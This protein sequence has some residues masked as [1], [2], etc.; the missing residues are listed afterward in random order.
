MRQI[1]IIKNIRDLNLKK[2]LNKDK[3]KTRYFIVMFIN[4]IFWTL[5]I[6]S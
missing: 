5:K 4:H 6:R 2:Y 3:E 1:L